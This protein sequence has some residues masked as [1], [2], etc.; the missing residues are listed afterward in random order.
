VTEQME[1][2][3]TPADV[4]E[5][6][7]EVRTPVLITV[8]E[9]LFSTAAAVPLRT[10]RA[11]WRTAVLAVQ[12]TFAAAMT[13]EL[14]QERRPPQHHPKRLRYLEGARMEREMSRL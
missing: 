8:A 10:A 7:N 9:V 4:R 6:R 11:G 1:R 12:Q 5:I 2:L 14:S 3:V 13:R